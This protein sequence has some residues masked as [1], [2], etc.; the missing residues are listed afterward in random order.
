MSKQNLDELLEQ[1]EEKIEKGEELD[2]IEA[3]HHGKNKSGC[4]EKCKHKKC[5]FFVH[6]Y[7]DKN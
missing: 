4:E 1:A 5:D 6:K 7:K 3:D 2:S